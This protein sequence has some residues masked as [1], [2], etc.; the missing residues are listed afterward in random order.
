MHDSWD[1]VRGRRMDR[2]MVRQTEKVIYRGECPTKKINRV[3][4][5]WDEK[6]HNCKPNSLIQ[7]LV[8]WSNIHCSKIYQRE[9]WKNNSST[10][11]L[12]VRTRYFRHR[13][14]IKF[15]RIPM[16]LKIIKPHQCSLEGSHVVLIEL[17]E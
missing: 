13:Y 16:N 5:S 17:K 10:L 8:C 6:K 15:S 7:T 2:H 3:K 9:N 1:M 11:H 14:S 4:P 12:E